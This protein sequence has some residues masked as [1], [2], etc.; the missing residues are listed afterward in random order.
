[1]IVHQIIQGSGLAEMGRASAQLDVD[2]IVYV[3]YVF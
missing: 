3:L 1:M 2:G